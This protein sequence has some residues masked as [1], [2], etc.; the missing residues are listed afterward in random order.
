M[1]LVSR[2][3]RTAAGDRVKNAVLARLERAIAEERT[4][5]ALSDAF[6]EFERAR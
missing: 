1:A 6:S 4:A 2:T 5:R 3:C